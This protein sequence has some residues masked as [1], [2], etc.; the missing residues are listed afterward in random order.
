MFAPPRWAWRQHFHLDAGDTSRYLAIQDTGLLRSMRLH[1]IGRHPR[2][3]RAT[4]PRVAAHL[5]GH[6]GP[7][8]TVYRV[9][10]REF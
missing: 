10:F 2:T 5:R 9:K 6:A 4:S 7:A 3:I 8:T 1:Q